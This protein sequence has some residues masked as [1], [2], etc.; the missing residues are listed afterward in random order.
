MFHYAKTAFLSFPRLIFFHLFKMKKW[1]KHLD[2]YPREMRYQSIRKLAQRIVRNFNCEINVFGLENIP[3][4]T[5]FFI[6]SNHMSA[7]DPLPYMVTYDKPLAFI[8]K[9][10][11]KKVP[12]LPT[13]MKVIEADYIDRDD[14]RQSLGV[15]LNVE[16]DLKKHEKSWMIFPEGTRIRDQLL[17]VGNFHHGTFRPAV[18]AGVPVVPAAIYGSFRVLKN[19]PTFKKYPVSI[20]FLKPIMPSDYKGL[21][22]CDIAKMTQDAIQR[23]ITYH[24]RP[25]DHKIMSESKDKKYK[26]TQV[27]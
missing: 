14:L 19:K 15:M 12:I 8:G 7:F 22:T 17:K 26:F 21:P 16:D 20:S 24:L 18:K 23:E 5:N 27:L 4:D 6:V 2:R 13:A 25:L 3:S 1:A 11:L 10:E 9:M